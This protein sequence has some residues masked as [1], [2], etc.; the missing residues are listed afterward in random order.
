MGAWWQDVRYGLRML[1]GSPGFSLV[2]VA[3]VAIGVGAS[4]TVFSILSPILL[5]PFPYEESDRIVAVEGR[6]RAGRSRQISNLDFRDWR[7]QATSFEELGCWTSRSRPVSATPDEPPEECNIQRVSDDFFRVFRVRPAVGRLLTPADDVPGAARVVILGHAFWQRHFGADPNALGRSLVVEGASHTI[8]GITPADFDFPPYGEKATD[9]WVAIAPTV[10]PGGRKERDHEVVARL[11]AGVSPEAA[12]AEVEAICARVAAEY[13]SNDPIVSATV[14]NLHDSMTDDMSPLPAILMGAVLT[15]FLVACANVAGLLFA[16]GVTRERE[17]ALR[18]ALGG[19][20]LRLMRLILM[21]DVVLALLGGGLGVL[22]S[23]W[24]V[25]LLLAAGVLPADVFPAGFFRPD[26]HVYGFALALSICGAPLCGLVPS[27]RC[28]SSRLAGSLA[29]GG[30]SVLGSRG[31]SAAHTGLLAAQ[32]ALTIVLLVAAGLMIRSLFQVFTADRGFNSHNVLVMDLHLLGDRY[33][34]DQSKAA[35]HRQ[36]LEQLDALPGV[37]KAALTGPLFGT[38]S[39]RFH[40]EGETVVPPGQSVATASYRAVSPGYFQAMGIRLLGGRFFADT[41]RLASSP[42]VIVDQTL[43]LR[44]WPAGN[45]LGQRL[46]LSESDDPNVPWAEVVGVVRHVQD[47]YE[48]DAR[49]Q[50]YEPLFQ[51]VFPRTSIVVRTTHPPKDFV[52]A[53]KAAV[54]RLDRQQLISKPRTLDEAMWYDTLARRFVAVLLSASAG[55]ALF[56]SAVGIYAVTRYSIARRTQEFGLRM[57]LGADRRAV[58]RLVLHKALVPVLVGLA[59]GLAFAV[60]VARVLS[61]LL[62]QLSPWDPATYAAVSVLLAAVTLLACYLPARRAAR[63][64]PM[65]AL[66]CE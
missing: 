8:V 51:K 9:V 21:E 47:G 41:D 23:T 22:V 13:P 19:T 16:R 17:M 52:A 53:V 33:A 28:S 27:L 15:V 4:T 20:R 14:Q 7:Q 2:V 12:Q 57:A 59:L 44:C 32:I 25:R 39:Q 1:G 42:V 11:K 5:R 62:A 34:G 40:L 63:T 60:A 45:W 37:E 61:S 31:R 58:L 36:L 10:G 35:F 56:L 55:I 65:A 46:K 6:D 43:A 26:R 3:L 54:Y 38:Q 66:R 18:S 49:M 48:R 64:D 30:R 50:M 24:I 29:A